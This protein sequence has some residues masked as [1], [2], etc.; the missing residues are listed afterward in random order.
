MKIV[1]NI[2]NR[3]SYKFIAIKNISKT[4]QLNKQEASNSM[5][6]H[7]LENVIFKQLN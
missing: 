4:E 1:K 3:F 7:I 5:Y 2:L 6:F